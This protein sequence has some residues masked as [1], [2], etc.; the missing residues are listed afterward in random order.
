MSPIP[1]LA[2]ALIGLLGP[3]APASAEGPAKP[4][5]A[6]AAPARLLPFADRVEALGTLKA[7]E[8]VTLTVNVTETVSAV[9]FEDG[10][11][12]R[13]G[14]VLVEMTDAEEQ[15]LIVE[16]KARVAEAV[17]QY[18]RVKSLAGQRSAAESLLDERL[19]DLETARAALQAIESRLA[20][21]VIRA[22]FDGVLGLRNIS[23]GALVEPGDPVATLDDMGTMKLDFAVPSVFLPDLKAGL[24]I[25]ARASAFPDLPF[26][27]RVSGIDSRI[28]PVTRSVTV[29]ALIPN[30]EGRLKPGLL[31]KVELLRNPR[32]AL[33]IPEAALLSKG[34]ERFVMRV[35]PGDL[36]ERVQ[37]ETGARRSG[38]V[39]ILSGIRA[40]DLVIA[41]GNDKVKPGQSVAVRLD[42]GTRP[43][44]ELLGGPTGPQPGP[45]PGPQSGTK[46]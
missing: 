24:A 42:D 44:R 4:V 30:P 23:A 11:R 37:V 13:R 33:L 21:R 15:A 26:E 5:P 40:G 1:G 16:G 34:R 31:M 14:E 3:C 45:Q 12:V 25:E 35:G 46:P 27:G 20:D 10:Q 19:R 36:A 28:D 6:I 18:D 22:P 38:E 39:E 32:Q 17:R 7:N 43:L 9:H 29:R 41:H 8:S 2:L